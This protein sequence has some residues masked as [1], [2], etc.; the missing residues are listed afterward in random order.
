MEYILFIHNNSELPPTQEQWAAFFETAKT[1]GMFRGGSEISQ[2]CLIG[3]KPINHVS[4]NIGG[5]MRFETSNK[6]ELLQLL[7]K[8][9]VA[10]Q[11]GTLE[12]CKMPRS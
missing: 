10:I 9:P 2:D 4:D 5:F 3:G 6:N 8:H 12:L 7:E 11:G 1:S